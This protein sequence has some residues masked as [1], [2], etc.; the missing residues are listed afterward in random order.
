[1]AAACLLDSSVII[2][3]INGRNHR[4]EMLEALIAEG[5]LLACCSF[6]I[7]E[8]YMGM[9]PH[10]A[11]TTEQLLDSLEF[12]PVTPEIAKYAG[13]L[14]RK[15]RQKGLTLALPDLTIA[16]VAIWSDLI[17]A[18]D[19]PKDFPMPELRLRLLP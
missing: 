9:C 17:F 4:N 8:V 1:M 14:Y 13:E 16:A 5:I 19:N 15:S 6:N 12:Y 11:K 18:T 7:T 3:A 10:E 2:D